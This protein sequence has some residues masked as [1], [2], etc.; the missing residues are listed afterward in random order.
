MNLDAYT[1]RKIAPRILFAVIGVNLSIYLCV[2][3][4]DVTNIF[5]GGIADLLRAPFIDDNSF[6]KIPDIDT[7]VESSI[8]GVVGAGGVAIGLFGLASGVAA[9]SVL[10][11]LAMFA[12]MIAGVALVAI[13]ILATLVI[14]YGAILFLSIV[15]PIAIALWVLPGTEKY[16]RTWWD[17]FLKVLI[18]YPIIAVIFAVSDILASIF[19][20]TN[21]EVNDISSV[22]SVF[23]AMFVIYA[24]LFMI[25]FAFK[26]SG[27]IVS[28]FYDFANS[29]G[30]QPLNKRLNDWKKDP[31]S[32]YGS[33]ANNMKDERYARGATFKQMSSGLTSG[34]DGWRRA[35][36][37]GLRGRAG[38]FRTAYSASSGTLGDTMLQKSAAKRQEEL[39]TMELIKGNDDIFEALSFANSN[40]DA[41][42]DQ[43]ARFLQNKNADMY[44]AAGTEGTDAQA[45]TR[46]QAMALL[47]RAQGEMSNRV[48]QMVAGQQAATATTFGNHGGPGQMA[49][50]A[51]DSG[52]TEFGQTMQA[53]KMKTALKGINRMDQ[54]GGSSAK[55][56][57]LMAQYQNGDLSEEDFANAMIDSAYEKLTPQQILSQDHNG[58]LAFAERGQERLRKAIAGGNA[59][60]I[61]FEAANLKTLHE[62]ISYS[63]VEN[64]EDIMDIFNRE[65]E[66][67]SITD[68]DRAAGKNA[69]AWDVVNQYAEPQYETVREEV[70]KRDEDGKAV[71]DASGEAVKETRDVQKRV[72]MP[73]M[74]TYRQ[75]IRTYDSSDIDPTTGQ[76]RGMPPRS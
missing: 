66:G 54:A 23:V 29:R 59:D 39:N 42:Y 21:D 24:P 57:G 6:K 67:V 37:A 16:F 64:K 68:E 45:A 47:Q 1:L 22:V 7:S 20:N 48:G 60:E 15:S 3:A 43:I 40:P 62:G 52:G 19:L 5:G 44:G 61:A 56:L 28:Q 25:P 8:V 4:I 76:P 74:A 38:S 58:M 33:R 32:Y 65:I 72:E 13:A 41:S 70:I 35:K 2:A 75:A 63:S 51:R 55:M 14:R 30:V 12:I 46:A 50:M 53:L 9:L 18:M 10:E 11:V 71:R 34:I 36:G 73:G 69:T 27:G 31:N 17:T 26:L 49:R